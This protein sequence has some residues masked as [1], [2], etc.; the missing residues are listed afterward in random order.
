MTMSLTTADQNGLR[1]GLAAAG[2]VVLSLFATRLHAAGGFSAFCVMAVV[3][4]AVSAWAAT[5]DH[6]VDTRR[7]IWI[8]LGSAV[9][10]RIPFL[11]ADPY[12]SS[13]LYRYI[14]DGRVQA[15]GINPFRFV[16]A[17][18]ELTALRD[19]VIYPNINRADYA[20]TI[21]PPAGQMWFFL[22]TRISESVLAM[23]LGMLAFEA[24][25]LACLLDM[26]RHLDLPPQRIA[27]AAWHPLALWEIAG[28]AHI[29]AA[30]TGCMLLGVWLFVTKRS[31]PG[32]VV[33]AIATL[34]KPI[35]IVA[36]PVFWKP[37]DLRMPGAV[38]AIVALF[39][40]P[41]LSVGAKVFGFASG[42]A[43][44]EGYK[45]G[46]GFWYPDLL[47]AVTGPIPGIGRFYLV[48]AALGFCALMLR[49]AFRDNRSDRATV[50]ALAL[51]TTVFLVLLTPH[52]PWYY[53]VAVPFL[54]IYPNSATLWVITVGA[55]QM[56]DVIPNDAVPDFGRRQ[57]VFHTIVLLAILWDLHA[58]T[59]RSLK[60]TPGVD[61]R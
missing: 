6:G 23:K 43:A 51:L 8:I 52:Y 16:P 28:N 1:L 13:D 34:I 38:I 44:E 10:M 45:A 47:Q 46:G 54:V 60:L 19:T 57:L 7:A 18:P 40:L 11:L 24:L 31:I 4:A 14:W 56:H 35:A 25:G 33:V 53:L 30:M 26:L 49:V 17:A 22:I 41:Y 59:Y 61:A 20:P 48:V 15:H 42:Y 9:L 58:R 32:A 36:L 37:W 21:Y 2:L 29:D 3:M 27:A 12:L 55:L 5:A 39:Y 50:E